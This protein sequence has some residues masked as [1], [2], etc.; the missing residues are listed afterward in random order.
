[1]LRAQFVV[2]ATIAEAGDNIITTSYLYG[3]TYNQFKVLFKRW[4]I[5]FRFVEGDKPEDF[6]KLIDDRTRGIYLET[7]GNPRYNVPDIRAFADLAHQHNI[8]LIV[9]NTFGAVRL[10]PAVITYQMS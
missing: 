4:G 9:D 7:I 10:S 3:G 2:F 5:E 1:M 6:A 8:P